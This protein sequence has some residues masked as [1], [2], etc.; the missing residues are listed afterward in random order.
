MHFLKLY[1]QLHTNSFNY[2]S[3]ADLDLDSDGSITVFDI[4]LIKREY[5]RLVGA[6]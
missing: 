2:E 5:F 6:I 3:N 4:A 1:Q